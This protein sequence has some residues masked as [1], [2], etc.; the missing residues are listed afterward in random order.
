V[1]LQQTAVAIRTQAVTQAVHPATILEEIPVTTMAAETAT[2]LRIDD[3]PNRL[4]S[5]TSNT[6]KG[7]PHACGCPFA[8]HLPPFSVR[9]ILKKS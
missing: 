7:H 6:A 9:Y 4:R 2:T 5:R 8:V 3:Q 1:V